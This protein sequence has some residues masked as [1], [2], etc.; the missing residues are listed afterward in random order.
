L[1]TDQLDDYLGRQEGPAAVL[2]NADTIEH[3]IVDAANPPKDQAD[4]LLALVT[5]VARTGALDRAG[6]RI[7]RS[8]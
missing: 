8:R 3:A 2:P 7:G 1:S 4:D 6:A 5:A